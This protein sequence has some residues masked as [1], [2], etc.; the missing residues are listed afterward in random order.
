MPIQLDA[1]FEHL[2]KTRRVD[3]GEPLTL[4]NVVSTVFRAD[5]HGESLVVKIGLS[6]RAATEVRM[7]CAGYEALQRIGASSLVPDP[8]EYVEFQDIPILIME[9]CGPDFW[10]A[11]RAS[12]DPAP[13]Y[14]RLFWAMEP[15][16]AKTRQRGGGEAYLESLRRRLLRQYQVHL[17][18]LVPP[19]PVSRLADADLHDLNPPVLCFASFDFTPED[20]FL[21]DKGARFADPLN[22]VI[23][24]PIVDLACFGGVAR[25]AY[26][27]PGSDEGYRDL[28]TLALSALPWLLELSGE[29]AGR[30]FALGRALQCAIS[31]RFRL[32]TDPD[33]A[34]ELAHRSES[35]LT[36]F[37]AK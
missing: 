32:N 36:E 10:H 2:S 30:F 6:E 22:E 20:V 28:E 24:V 17:R 7:N 34:E 4:G 18:G 19:R 37:L 15:V 13:L 33:R 5:R 23:G 29:Q 27:L 21:T 12:K 14:G 3:C 16:Y 31:A 25:D 1:I 26:G 35:F 8:L 11:V 9:D